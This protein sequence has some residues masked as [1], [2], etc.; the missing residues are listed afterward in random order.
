[1]VRLYWTTV[2]PSL[3]DLGRCLSITASS[4]VCDISVPPGESEIRE[5]TI[6]LKECYG[7]LA[8]I[9]ADNRVGH[10]YGYT[11]VT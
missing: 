10:F 7:F 1:M 9:V 11:T 3:S 6:Q 4:A 5:A 8:E 2:V